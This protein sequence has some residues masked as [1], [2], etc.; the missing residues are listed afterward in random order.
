MSI[1]DGL[2]L[3]V[4]V[5][6]T[7]GAFGYGDSTVC[8]L[9]YFGDVFATFYGAMSIILGFHGSSFNS[10]YFFDPGYGF[11]STRMFSILVNFRGVGQVNVYNDYVINYFLF[12]TMNGPTFVHVT[13]TA[14]GDVFVREDLVMR[15]GFYVF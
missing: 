10:T 2:F 12:V 6:T 13:V 4:V 3:R 9:G 8:G 1:E 15:V 14:R 5:Y 11:D 7:I